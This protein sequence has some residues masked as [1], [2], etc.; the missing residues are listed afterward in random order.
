M[1]IRNK[2]LTFSTSM[3]HPKRVPSLSALKTNEFRFLED[4]G[5]ERTF[6]GFHAVLK[7]C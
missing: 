2:T 3:V 1:A 5:F 6:G 7:Q 4:L